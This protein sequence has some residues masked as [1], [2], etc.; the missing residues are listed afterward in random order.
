MHGED[1]RY[2]TY[3]PP[4]SAVISQCTGKTAPMSGEIQYFPVGAAGQSRKICRQLRDGAVMSVPGH[5][6]QALSP[7]HAPVAS[8]VNCQHGKRRDECTATRYTENYMG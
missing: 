7:T 1:N 2:M 3:Q 5:G 4:P 8:H 6:V